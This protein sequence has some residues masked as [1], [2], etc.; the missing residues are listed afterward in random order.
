[1]Y[2]IRR[3]YKTQPGVASDVAKLVYEQAKIYRDAGHRGDFTVS[4]NGYTLPGEQN[5]VI[6]EW[7]DESIQSP[8]RAGN[9]VPPEAIEVA[10]KYRPLLESQHIEFYEM[11]DPKTM[12]D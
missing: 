9:K 3:V 5:I 10:K 8:S 7:Q 4:Y 12:G 6:L 2:R 1:M 11:V